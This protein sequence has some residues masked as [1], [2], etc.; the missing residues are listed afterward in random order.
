[1]KMERPEHCCS[2]RL[3]PRL[4]S[5]KERRPQWKPAQVALQP[6]LGRVLINEERWRRAIFC[7]KSETVSGRA[8]LLSEVMISLH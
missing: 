6:G 5:E 8:T 3:T 4:K 2:D 1:M 7:V